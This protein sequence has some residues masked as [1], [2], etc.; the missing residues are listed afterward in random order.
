MHKK[1]CL[2][3]KDCL[4]CDDKILR[5]ENSRKAKKKAHKKR[6]VTSSFSFRTS[7]LL[8]SVLVVE[9]VCLV[10]LFMVIVQT[11]LS[12]SENRDLKIANGILRGCLVTGDEIFPLPYYVSYIIY[13]VETE[14]II[15][16]NNPFLPLLDETEKKSKHYV[17][18]NYF[19]DGDLNILYYAK[20]IDVNDK[21]YM[22]VT[23]VD[24]DYETRKS[25]LSNVP[26]ALVFSIVPILLGSFLF[27][28]LTAK[29][30]IKP[31]I[32]ITKSAQNISV[33]NLDEKLP[34]S[35]FN[36]EIDDLSNTFNELFKRL[37]L[38]FDREKQFS[39]DVS[40]ELKTPL[41]VISGQTNLLLRWGKN[42]SE[43]LEKSLLAIRD[44]TKSMEAIINNLLEITRIE[45]GRI[46]PKNE[47]FSIADLFERLQNEFF[48]IAPNAKIEYTASENLK[49]NNDREMLHQ[50]LTVAMSNSL[51]FA[52]ENCLISL[53]AYSEN[54]R[55]IISAQDD[56]CGFGEKNIS[57]VFD[58]F[59]C[60]DEARTRSNGGCGLG[61]SIAKTLITAMGGT[62]EAED[63]L[64]HGACILITLPTNL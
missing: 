45:S 49:I 21:T 24:R 54:D 1:N 25:M 11:S 62:I 26:I 12:E 17:S 36:D 59:Y 41:A 13:D 10:V 31:V 38:D 7:V 42:D 56:G 57:H 34:T 28:F 3:K 46:K 30:T 37:K 32:K 35:K 18:R 58:R 6:N 23:S 20:P 16:T 4:T 40:H 14:E 60:A 53:C 55:I 52:G 43:Q 48:H 50:V 63:V 61:L 51:K 15:I 47:D 5:E 8:T 22:V 2:I 39:S 44:E 33:S 64:P 27:T 19:S 29:K 9:I